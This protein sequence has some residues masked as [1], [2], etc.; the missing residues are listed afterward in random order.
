MFR[1][2]N[3]YPRLADEMIEGNPDLDDGCRAWKTPRPDSRR[4]Y[5]RELK[6]VITRYDELKPRRATMMSPTPA[7]CQ[8]RQAPS[9]TS[10]RSRCSVPGLVSDIDGSVIYSASGRCETYSV[11]DEVGAGGRCT[12]GPGSWGRRGK[13]LPDRAPAGRHPPLPTLA[14]SSVTI[15]IFWAARLPRCGRYLDN[16]RAKVHASV[17]RRDPAD[18]LSWTALIY[19]H[20]ARALL[21]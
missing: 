3:T 8:Q 1:S 11:V 14:W 9:I 16:V 18:E 10:R 21:V 5:S 19:D 17:H 6:A 15:A 20:A 12:L 2:L 4:L 13:N 7:A